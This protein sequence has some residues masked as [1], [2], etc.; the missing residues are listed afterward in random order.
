M[1]AGQW[2]A[3][4]DG[5]R[6]NWLPLTG[7]ALQGRGGEAQGKLNQAQ[8]KLNRCTMASDDHVDPRASGDAATEWRTSTMS[9]STEQSSENVPD[10]IAGAQQSDFTVADVHMTSA[11]KMWRWYSFVTFASI[12]RCG[13]S[14]WTCCLC[15]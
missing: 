3:V 1:T 14:R 15:R 8:G 2:Q 10:E 13:T 4:P 11:S 7:R 6:A 12:S 9:F 5:R